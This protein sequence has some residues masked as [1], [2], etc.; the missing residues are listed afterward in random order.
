[1][2]E[3]NKS[4]VQ[5]IASSE[6]TDL[7]ATISDT[8]LDAAISSGAL[9]GVPIFGTAASIWRAG[10][11]IQHEL[12]IRK[13]VKFLAETSK[14]KSEDRK[15]FE[16]NLKNTGKIEEFGEAILHIID[17]IDDTKKPIIVGRL[18]SAHMK[19]LIE[20]SKTMRLA[21]IV[22]RCY[23]QDLEL[24]KDFKHGVQ[25]E[26]TPIAETLHSIGLLSNGGLDGGDV[27]DP[28]SSGVIYYMNEFGELLLRHGLR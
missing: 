3:L 19:G 20:Y 4:L 6:T 9:D 22:S 25:R 26:S 24:L 17:K 11:E 27:S 15:L 18:V 23:V 16:K 2:S 10:K 1:M 8:A 21:S 7:I 5:S 13:I 14:V 12:F 28:L